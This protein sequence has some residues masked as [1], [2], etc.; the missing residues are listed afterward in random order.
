MPNPTK[1]ATVWVAV[2]M[3]LAEVG[4][5]G[6]LTASGA[7]PVAAVWDA[8][9]KNLSSA[10]SRGRRQA[11]GPKHGFHPC[12]ESSGGSCSGC[13]YS[14][15]GYNYVQCP[16]HDDD[17]IC[18]YA[19][20]PACSAATA[21]GYNNDHSCDFVTEYRSTGA[22]ALTFG[23]CTAFANCSLG[24]TY[25]TSAPTP[26]SDR[27]C[28][29][30]VNC[31]LGVTYTT[32]PATL[33]D[34]T[35]CAAVANCSGASAF[36]T[37]RA[38]L[39]S[40]TNCSADCPGGQFGG[41][42]GMTA[43]GTNGTAG[44]WYVCTQLTACITPAPP[45]QLTA[46]T[47]TTNRAC[48]N[49]SSG[50]GA[51]AYATQ[52]RTATSS[53]YACA[54]WTT[55][56]VPTPYERVS[57]TPTTDRVCTANSSCTAYTPDQTYLSAP[58]TSTS[59]CQYSPVTNCT[60]SQTDIL[61]PTATT[62][63]VCLG[64]CA[65]SQYISHDAT[66]TAS[67]QTISPTCPTWQYQSDAP[68]PTVRNRQCSSIT[69]CTVGENFQVVAPTPT[70]NRVCESTTQCVAGATYATAM[71]TTTTNRECAACQTCTA[72]QPQQRP[73]TVSSDR[74]CAS[75]LANQ[76]VRDG[77]ECANASTSCPPGMYCLQAA[78]PHI[79]NR[80]CSQVTNCTLG[81]TYQVVA[82]DVDVC[83]SHDRVCVAV[84][85]CVLNVTFQSVLPT[86]T[87]NRQCAAVTM[88][89]AGTSQLQPPTLT[90]D[91]VCTTPTPP[92]GSPTTSSPT[93]SPIGSPT[94]SSP[95]ASQAGS[96]TTSSQTASPT[97]PQTTAPPTA[98]PVAV[99][100]SSDHLTSTT[101]HNSLEEVGVGVGVGVIVLLAAVCAVVFAR[102][103]MGATTGRGMTGNVQ[104]N[105]LHMTPLDSDEVHAS[106]L[107]SHEFIYEDE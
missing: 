21:I 107:L 23:T 49:Q 64:H 48:T 44:R 42:G 13:G 102:R 84:R 91:R 98:S 54:N 31:T 2:A 24:Q 5:K 9:L 67:C 101:K 41:P 59:A 85:S 99:P 40:D 43:N 27:V 83:G 15:S 7:S 32:R 87:S 18:V 17:G 78:V 57:P 56:G 1:T 11:Y 12:T 69:N 81:I 52:T 60:A 93:V 72:P 29:A 6:A 36:Q 68:V 3:M 73:C 55:C 70:T 75:C 94:M 20:C 39:T 8:N 97:G 51:G 38:T 46:P 14:C 50:C 80:V 90:T 82:P 76:Y 62:D 30:V 88:C 77:T 106:P 34:N 66:P 22:T 47:S 4:A 28:S 26:T 74:V 25:Q 89:P 71:P 105:P 65:A 79:A 16:Q 96:P 61:P 104:L 86:L 19:Q 35:A 95:T 37:A 33:L 45:Y 10:L 103:R 53:S 92:A 63:R 100:L 58:A